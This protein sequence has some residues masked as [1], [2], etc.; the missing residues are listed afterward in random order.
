LINPKKQIFLKFPIE[1]P[2]E[3]KRFEILNSLKN[4]K[5]IKNSVS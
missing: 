5:L 2:L 4:D 1:K 3:E